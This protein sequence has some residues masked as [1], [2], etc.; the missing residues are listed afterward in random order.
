MSGKHP[1]QFVMLKHFFCDPVWQPRKG[2]EK[3][4][5]SSLVALNTH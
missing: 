4:I 1:F 5:S 2:E 3:E